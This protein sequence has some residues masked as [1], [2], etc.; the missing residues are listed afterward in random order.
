[1]GSVR[2][3]SCSFY[4]SAA[5]VQLEFGESAAFIID[6]T[7]HVLNNYWQTVY[8]SESCG[9]ASQFTPSLAI[10]SHTELGGEPKWIPLDFGYHDVMH[11]DQSERK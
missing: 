10:P 5:Y 6:F 9:N 4:L 1:M 2:F 3:M 11:A 7:V 8:Q